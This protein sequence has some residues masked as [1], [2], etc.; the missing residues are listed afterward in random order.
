MFNESFVPEN[1]DGIVI[2]PSSAGISSFNLVI[3][4]LGER[5]YVDDKFIPN[6]WFAYSDLADLTLVDN[7]R[8]SVF[9]VKRFN[10]SGPELEYA[11]TQGALVESYDFS[12]PAE[13]LF[14]SWLENSRSLSVYYHSRG[15]Q[16]ES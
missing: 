10:L 12:D 13:Y 16:C 11:R 1:A 3:D 5:L 7:G 8:R 15:Q 4:E 9:E 6:S 14:Q 2:L